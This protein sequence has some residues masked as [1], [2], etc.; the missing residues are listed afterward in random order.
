MDSERKRWNLEHVVLDLFSHFTLGKIQWLSHVVLDLSLVVA[1]ASA[2]GFDCVHR[3]PNCLMSLL[4]MCAAVSE[5]AASDI[6]MGAQP[7]GSE[8]VDTATARWRQ[9][10]EGAARVGLQFP[11]LPERRGRG[12]PR[13]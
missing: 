11:F 5:A 12:A 3:V 2:I 13:R 10:V 4:I 8:L 6:L 1:E 9:R 7:R